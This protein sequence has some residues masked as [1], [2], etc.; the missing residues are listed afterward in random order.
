MDPLPEFQ[1]VSTTL[2]NFIVQ[3]LEQFQ[4]TEHDSHQFNLRLIETTAVAIHEISVSL[5]RN[6][7]KSHDEDEISRVALWQTPFTVLHSDGRLEVLHHPPPRPTLFNHYRYNNHENYPE[8]LAETS[9]YWA[10]VCVH[11]WSSFLICTGI[12]IAR[13]CLRG[14]CSPY[15]LRPVFCRRKPSY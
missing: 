6:K 12:H 3:V 10:E 7:A 9:G 1:L 11:V 8:G 13:Q 4:Q 14:L 5:F 2:I 15:L